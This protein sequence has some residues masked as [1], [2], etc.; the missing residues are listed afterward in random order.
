MDM[1]TTQAVDEIGL[2][3]M[4]SQPGDSDESCDELR[5]TNEMSS[6]EVESDLE[7]KALLPNDD[8]F[9]AQAT[10]S[11]TDASV[12]QERRTSL[13]TKLL[14]LCTYFVLNLG[15]TLSNKAVLRTVRLREKNPLLRG[16]L[17]GISGSISMASHNSARFGDFDWLLCHGCARV[18][19]DTEPDHT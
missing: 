18:P 9:E 11:N 5:K 2:V 10:D 3:R 8:R 7:A 1:V 19:E 17:M 13:R 12:P 6:F 4:Q 15:L 14:F 16:K